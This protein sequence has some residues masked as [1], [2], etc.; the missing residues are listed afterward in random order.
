[1]LIF[2]YSHNILDFI[3]ATMDPKGKTIA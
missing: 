3:T 1:L 2:P